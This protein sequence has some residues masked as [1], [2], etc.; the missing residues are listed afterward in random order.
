[1]TVG[2]RQMSHDGRRTKDHHHSQVLSTDEVKMDIKR[3]HFVTV[4]S[5]QLR[6]CNP[7]TAYEY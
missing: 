3:N 4:S 7:P 2:G 1:M 5:T 6:I